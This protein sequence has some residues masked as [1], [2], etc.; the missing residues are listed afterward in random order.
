M[1][2]GYFA[3][4][5]DFLNEE[6]FHKEPASRGQAW[7]ELIGLAKFKDEPFLVNG[8]LVEGKRGCI[9]VSQTA[10]SER[11]KWS[12]NKVIRFLKLLQTLGKIELRSN[13]VINCISIVN[14]STNTENGTAVGTAVE[15]AVETTVE[16]T[17]ETRLIKNIK[18]IKKIKKYISS[19]SGEDLGVLL[20]FDFVWELYGKRGTKKTAKSRY[21]K[22]SKK[23]KI[24]VIEYIPY[25][26]AFTEPKHRKY[27]EVFISREQWTNILQDQNGKQIPF[28]DENGDKQYHVASVESFKEWFNALVQ[29]TAIPQVQDVTPERHVNLNI[30]YTLYPKLMETAVKTVLTNTRYIEMANKGMITFD[31]IFNPANLVKICE[32]GGEQ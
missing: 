5:R 31:Y 18:K 19:L 16:T 14:Y 23:N 10:L 30:C 12:K 26:L 7:I 9:Y 2:K 29:G 28:I 4:S 6:I 22:L 27:F 24:S 8:Q 21:E 13:H 3:V 25:Y 32:K 1:S 17:V 11:W 20:S 15:T